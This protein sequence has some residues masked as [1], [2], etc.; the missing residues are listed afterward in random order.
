MLRELGAHVTAVSETASAL[1][2]LNAEDFDVVLS[3]IAR[4]HRPDEGLTALRQINGAAPAAAVIF[5][6]GEVDT[7]AGIPIGASGIT[8]EPAELLHL[9]LDALERRRL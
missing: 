6:V 1:D 9:V 3:D 8:N 7:R 5:Y 2:C 4:G